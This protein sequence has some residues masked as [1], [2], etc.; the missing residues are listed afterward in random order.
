MSH[1]KRTRS[2]LVSQNKGELELEKPINIMLNC[3]FEKGEYKTTGHS[4]V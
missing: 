4:R 2:Q 3:K 1:S